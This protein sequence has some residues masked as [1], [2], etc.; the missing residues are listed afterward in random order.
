MTRTAPLQAHRSSTRAGTGLN[1]RWD[2]VERHVWAT[3]CL[4]LR[5]VAG[6][7]VPKAAGTISYSGIPWWGQ[8]TSRDTHGGTTRGA[9][10]GGWL[11]QQVQWCTS[12]NFT[13]DYADCVFTWWQRSCRCARAPRLFT[14]SSSDGCHATLPTQIP[15]PTARPPSRRAVRLRCPAATK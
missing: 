10:G 13:L 8:R 4:G 14:I 5:V 15:R 11:C 9:G 7:V 1:P 3:P 12:V 2:W 6:K